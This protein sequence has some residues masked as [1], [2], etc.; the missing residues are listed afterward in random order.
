MGMIDFQGMQWCHGIRDVQYFLINSLDEDLLAEHEWDL[1]DR[2]VAALAR[3]GI[4]LD[5]A[6]A[7]ERYRA[8]SFQTLMVA[9]VSLGLGSLTLLV[10]SGEAERLPTVSILFIGAL[11]GTALVATQSAN[12]GDEGGAVREVVVFGIVS[13]VL[14][15]C[16]TNW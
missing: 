6:E 16:T 4:V 13:V 11:F 12:L 15:R 5:R 10:I 2:Y 8:Y 3:H 14:G 9:V 7:Q 1:V